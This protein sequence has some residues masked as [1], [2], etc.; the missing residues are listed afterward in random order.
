MEH[1]DSGD[2]SVGET[3]FWQARGLPARARAR[4][5][6]HP[7]PAC[8]QEPVRGTRRA[9]RSGAGWSLSARCPPGPPVT[10]V[11]ENLLAVQA[12][13]RP[14]VWPVRTCAPVHASG[15]LGLLPL[16]GTDPAV[17]AGVFQTRSARRP[18][19]AVGSGSHVGVLSAQS[20]H[21]KD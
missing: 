16:L 20:G 15:T 19:V 10:G 1:S 12:E 21:W 7:S 11:S 3:P 17:D 18:E 8:A 14:V 13:P 6:E 5:P 4:T 2:T 9:R